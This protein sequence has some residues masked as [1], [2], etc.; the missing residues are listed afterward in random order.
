[1]S[2]PFEFHLPSPLV[3]L[4]HTC[5]VHCVAACC[6]LAAFDIAAHSMARWIEPQGMEA[7]KTAVGQLDELIEAVEREPGGVLSPMEDFNYLWDTGS[8]CVEYLLTWRDAIFEAQVLAAGPTQVQPDWLNWNNGV[9]QMLA[10]AIRQDRDSA[11]LLILA[12]ALEEAGCQDADLLWLCRHPGKGRRQG[13]AVELLLAEATVKPITP[14]QTAEL[15]RPHVRSSLVPSASRGW[16]LWTV[17]SVAG[18]RRRGYVT[19]KARIASRDRTGRV[20][21]KLVRRGWTVHTGPVCPKC[22]GTQTG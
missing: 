6:S 17:C 4:T 1:M 12:D 18:C 13:W 9:V 3:G 11:L 5:E 21:R 16:Y 8:A 7:V 19:S 14:E 22:R 2:K 20:C 15:L 10:Q